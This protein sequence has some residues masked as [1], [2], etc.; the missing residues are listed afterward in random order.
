MGSA[1][2]VDAPLPLLIA[3]LLI[4]G[5]LG[6]AWNGLAF[7]AAA[8]M[9]GHARAG[10][11][12]GLQGTIIRVVSAGAGVVFGFAV[13][14]SGSWSVAFFLLAIL[15]LASFALLT[16]L[17]KEEERRLLPSAVRAATQP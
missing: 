5:V 3:A 14:Q 12:I 1:L 10:M 7:T 13:E 6:L 17:T 15:P 2:V 9:A 16:P 4:A 8:E 11:A